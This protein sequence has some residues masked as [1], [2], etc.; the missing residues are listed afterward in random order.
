[1]D[2]LH[3][4]CPRMQLDAHWQSPTPDL[5]P[6]DE[7]ADHGATLAAMMGRLHL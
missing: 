5:E 4:G 6:P 3:D 7:P 1:M 2:F